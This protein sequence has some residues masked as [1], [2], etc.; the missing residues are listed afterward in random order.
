MTYNVFYGTLNL[1]LS[2]YVGEWAAGLCPR[3]LHSHKH[4]AISAPLG[5]GVSVIW[6]CP[7]LAAVARDAC[8]WQWCRQWRVIRHPRSFASDS[9]HLHRWGPLCVGVVAPFQAV[10][11][12]CLHGTLQFHL[13]CCYPLLKCD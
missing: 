13:Y 9:V 7:L 11:P 8:R 6:Q 5:H 1:V 4:D 10:V 12:P 2:I 3:R